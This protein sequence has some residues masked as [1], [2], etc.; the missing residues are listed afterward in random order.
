[1]LSEIVKVVDGGGDL[2]CCRPENF[3]FVGKNFRFAGK[4]LPLAPPLKHWSHGALVARHWSLLYKPSFG[5]SSSSKD[6]FPLWFLQDI[7]QAF[8]Q[9]RVRESE[10]DALRFHWRKSEMDEVETFRFAR[11]LFELAPSP[12]LLEGCLESH[13]DAWADRYP[14]EIALPRRSMYVDDV[15]SGGRTVQEVQARKEIRTRDIA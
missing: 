13:L 4:V 7:R 11:V 8:L 1:M 15:L 3:W 6:R 14:D 12:Y 10:R 9:I 2:K 5:M